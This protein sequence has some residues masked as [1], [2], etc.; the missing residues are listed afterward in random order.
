MCDFF[1]RHLFQW[2][3]RRF[4]FLGD[5]VGE[6]QIFW[7][8]ISHFPIFSRASKL[9]VGKWI[10]VSNQTFVAVIPGEA[11]V[12]MKRSLDQ[13][14]GK[15]QDVDWG[16]AKIVRD[17][18]ALVLMDD[19]P[20]RRCFFFWLTLRQSYIAMVIA[21]FNRKYIFNL[22]HFEKIFAFLVYL[23]WQQNLS[24]YSSSIFFNS[25]PFSDISEANFRIANLAALFGWGAGKTAFRL[26]NCQRKEIFPCHLV[27]RWIYG[28][29]QSGQSIQTSEKELTAPVG[30]YSYC[31][32]L[33]PVQFQ[34][35]CS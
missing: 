5:G 14:G 16:K 35:R 4:F 2:C 31:P 28:V 32:D 19:S 13:V 3:W 26:T 18:V 8:K 23:E 33:S 1:C 22:I 25:E 9:E 27:R 34:R 15:G 11:V 7:L 30:L 12:E 17:D 10:T 24:F 6:L 29:F 21:V 20:W